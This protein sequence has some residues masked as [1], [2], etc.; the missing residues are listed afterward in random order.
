VPLDKPHKGLE[1]WKLGMELCRDIYELC[2]RLPDSEKFGLSSQMKR[3]AVSIP[4]NIAEGAGRSTK[5]EFMQFLSIAQGS[6]AELDT[7]LE[8]CTD[9]LG[10]LE[11][12][13]VAQ[14]LE[15]IERI[16]MMITGL[17]KSLASRP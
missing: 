12:D 4:S 14:P 8:L 13:A 9:Y 6:L 15:K 16:S 3:S 2:L 7:Q 1:V 11:A 5:K 17:K 10:L